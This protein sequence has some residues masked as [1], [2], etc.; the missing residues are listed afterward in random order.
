M[1][2][3]VQY[4]WE[5]KVQ[6]IVLSEQ[7]DC[8]SLIVWWRLI[9][10][11]FGIVFE[12]HVCANFTCIWWKNFLTLSN[13]QLQPCIHWDGGMA[14]LRVKIIFR[15]S[16]FVLVS[17][18]NHWV[19]KKNAFLKGMEKNASLCQWTS[20]KLNTE[21]LSCRV[22]AIFPTPVHD[23]AALRDRRMGNLVSYARKVEGDMY[24]TANSRVC[25]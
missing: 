12:S 22:T 10:K 5:R 3:S 18:T 25:A 2:I 7:A 23:P 16:T 24:E 11:I 13:L 20:L 4:N 9:V 1:G 8:F 6:I 19:S 15:E 17:G 14:N 21:I